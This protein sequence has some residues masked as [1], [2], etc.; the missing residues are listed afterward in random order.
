VPWK[1]RREKRG[2][3]FSI[4]K[5]PGMGFVDFYP[6]RA[7]SFGLGPRILSRSPS[8]SS[9]APPENTRTIKQRLRKAS[10][11]QTK[12]SAA[13][14]GNGSIFRR[15]PLVCD[16]SR[17]MSLVCSSVS[18]PRTPACPRTRLTRPTELHV[19]MFLVRCRDAFIARRGPVEPEP[20]DRPSLPH[21]R[22]CGVL[23][24]AIRA[25]KIQGFWR[26]QILPA[27]LLLIH[28]RGSKIAQPCVPPGRQRNRRA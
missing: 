5:K 24:V 11:R 27:C 28:E 16:S 4:R 10:R 15:I 6:R 19:G 25:Q 3:F 7:S 12:G 20:P 1:L 9:P 13:P 18:S 21:N 23:A 22:P 8:S 14:C 26:E 2:A 17:M